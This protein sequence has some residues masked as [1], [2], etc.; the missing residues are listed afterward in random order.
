MNENQNQEWTPEQER[1]FDERMTRKEREDNNKA[2][3]DVVEGRVPLVTITPP[4]K[5]ES[6]TY[7]TM[8]VLPKKP[9]A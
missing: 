2:A 3:Q 9:S 6:I 4:S 8:P 7:P 1:E 5:V